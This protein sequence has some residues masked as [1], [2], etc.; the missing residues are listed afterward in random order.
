[1]SEIAAL[2]N[3][4][5]QDTWRH[6]VGFSPE[7]ESANREL[8]QFSSG[9]AGAIQIINEWIEQSQPCLFGRLAAKV[10][11]LSYCILTE[12]DL[13]GS[14]QHLLEK[15]QSARTEWKRE[16]LLGRKSGF[17]ISVISERIACSVPDDSVKALA[18][19][20]CSLYLLDETH[21]DRVC[22][23][24]LFLEMP[25]P[26]RTTW[27]WDTGVNY[28]SSHGD[29][30]WWHDHRFPGGLAF[31]INSVGH[32]VKS[33]MMAMHIAD[34][35]KLMGA[36]EQGLVSTRID[37]PEDALAYAML[38]IDNASDAISG[39]ATELLSLPA[40]VNELP[41]PKCPTK[42]PRIVEDKNYCEYK[43]YYHTDYTIPSEYFIANIERPAAICPHRL[44]FTYLFGDD[45]LSSDRRRLKEGV[46]IRGGK[47]SMTSP[48]T[49]I[50]K[51]E[52]DL[53]KRGKA[54]GTAV[55]SSDRPPAR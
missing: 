30:R 33:G 46:R 7:I 26:L 36:P 48:R 5:H 41:V 49:P 6:Q 40:N 18:L 44:D 3:N 45:P 17:I 9:E 31:S 4:L 28:F 52:V 22:L 37:S 38:T 43:G 16:G 42:L 12:D 32:M 11:L 35:A 25:G 27:K 8:F 34:L 51:G 24:D 13:L 54:Q 39:K 29:K 50:G 53:S 21:A 23:D 2:F 55:Q 10:G 1:M 19:R 20:I 47:K 15:I 14:E